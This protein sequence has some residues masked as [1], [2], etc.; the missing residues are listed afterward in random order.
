MRGHVICLHR[1]VP[2]WC[3]RGVYVLASARGHSFLSLRDEMAAEEKQAEADI[4][5]GDEAV[6]QAIALVDALDN[7]AVHEFRTSTSPGNDSMVVMG[8]VVALLSGVMPGVAWSPSAAKGAF[9]APACTCV[10]ATS[11]FAVS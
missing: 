6:T 2:S 10:C 3:A 9:P 11:R 4:A 7:R 1:V 8:A 5:E